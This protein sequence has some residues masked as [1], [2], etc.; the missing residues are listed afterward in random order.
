MTE[1]DWLACNDPEAMLQFLQGKV[2][3]RKLRLF[4]CACCRRIWDLI[5]NPDSR[6]AV[7]VSERYA[8]GRASEVDL[9][10]A[11]AQAVRR[12]G[13]ASSAAYF[14]ANRNPAESVS[15]ACGAALEAAALA[16]TQEARA[17]ASEAAD[18]R[19]AWNDFAAALERARAAEARAQADLLR[20]VAGNPF[21]EVAVEPSWL[22]WQGGTVRRLARAIYDER[23]FGDL[24]VLADALEE[25]GCSNV[26]IL[27][28]CRS[29]Q[30]HVRGCWVVDR[31]LEGT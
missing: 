30:E 13:E 1:A 7:E 22:A 18:R 29:G 28:H 19:A 8:D 12:S 27:E 6:Y 10:G 25:A 23:R 4:A 9:R 16:A 14:A 3:G 21:R 24:P 5:G 11:L 31:L 15:T 26:D 20:E 2:S 17:T